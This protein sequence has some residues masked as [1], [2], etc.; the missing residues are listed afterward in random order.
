MP[1]WRQVLGFTAFAMLAL[2][3]SLTLSLK[4]FALQAFDA[5]E[6]AQAEESVASVERAL[7]TMVEDV[8]ER[9]IDWSD[10]DDAVTYA[11][12]GNEDFEASNLIIPSMRATHWHL[13][14][15]WTPS[16]GF[17][18]VRYADEGFTAFQALPEAWNRWL[19]PDG[20]LLSGTASHAASRFGMAVL[21]GQ[22][23][24]VSSRPVRHSDMRLASAAARIVVGRRLDAR[25]LDRLRRLTRL[26]VTVSPL[27]A[28]PH[29]RQ[30]AAALAR[31]PRGQRRAIEEISESALV[32]FSAL[33]D[34]RGRPAVRVRVALPRA[35]RAQTREAL[36]VMLAA[37]GAMVL[38]ASLLAARGIHRTVVVPLDRLTD[39][40]R[41]LGHGEQAR[42]EVDGAS[43]FR[44]L[45]RSFNAMAEEIAAREAQLRATNEALRAARDT[46]QH[47]L[48]ARSAFLA[49]MSHEIRT[50]MNGVLGM[51][52]LLEDDITDETQRERVRMLRSAGEA[53][54][55]ILNDVLDLSKIEVGRLEVEAIPFDLRALCR[56]V[57]RLFAA[58]A[59]QRG[60]GLTLA[61]SPRL[62]ATVLGDPTRVRQVLVNLVGNA[63]KFTERGEVVIAV[64][65]DGDR[66]KISVRDTGIGI[67]PETVERLFEPF[68][69]ADSSFARRYGGTGLGLAI[70]HRLAE[71]MR[72]SLRVT[73]APGAGS[74]FTLD[75]PLPAVTE[76]PR[77]P[78]TITA[79]RAR[80][81]STEHAR[82][83]VVLAA[84]DNEVNRKLLGALLARMGYESVL[85]NDGAAV[86]EAARARR[87]D[88]VLM[89]CQMPV[90]DGFDATRA[91]RKAE[92]A[93]RH[94]PIIALTANA[95]T[96]DRE[97]CL[98]AGMDDYLTKPIKPRDL[99]ETLAR[100]VRRHSHEAV[101]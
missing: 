31:I 39:T 70:S 101:A 62:A 60:I 82:R 11:A 1:L 13:F 83:G 63:L 38:L 19:A 53:L 85:V 35:T 87:F 21:E 97:R 12:D 67:A 22:I 26:D 65:R 76:A 49:T 84:E 17:R 54:L 30:E 75:V 69:Q 43:E 6:R 3:A 68:S 56:D 18:A 88:A 58:P 42:A 45:A 28:T 16:A 93:G 71:L 47:A 8:D 44:E 73:S 33:D 100:W 29:D 86:I 64:T 72:G 55:T 89:D 10:W 5:S 40:V 59:Q 92:T 2:A 52:A 37:A 95:M 99:E 94:I 25:S 74:E 27:G 48:A 91:I 9:V 32:G 41:N 57:T 15:L 98:E 36:S 78:N 96:G 23:W 34:L 79:P 4:Y 51:A 61:L 14:A 80:V 50:P 20:P 46:A 90:V 66:V 77:R 81:A 24:I 7:A